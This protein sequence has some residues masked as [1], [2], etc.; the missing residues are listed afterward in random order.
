MRHYIPTESL[1]LKSAHIAAKVQ[2][3]HI[4]EIAKAFLHQILIKS[5]SSEHNNITASIMQ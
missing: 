1:K 5:K 3:Q 4:L 2:Q